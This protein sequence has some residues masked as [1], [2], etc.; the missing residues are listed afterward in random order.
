MRACLFVAVV[1]L[2]AG[3]ASNSEFDA[4][5]ELPVMS[6]VEPSG[7]LRVGDR[8]SI[9]FVV[10]DQ[11]STQ[12]V[13]DPDGVAV[14]PLV[15]P[16]QAAGRSVTDYEAD[17]IEL[18]RPRVRI[19]VLRVAR[20]EAAPRRVYVGGAVVQPGYVDIIGTP[21]DV[22]SAIGTVGGPNLA[23]AD[24]AHVV[25]SRVDEHGARRAW[26]CDL[27][28]AL[29]DGSVPE[30]IE[31]DVVVVPNTAVVRANIAVD[32]YITRMVPGLSSFAFLQANE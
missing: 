28:Q 5:P 29:L 16:I 10:H 11:L 7:E 23:T 13:V 25:V 14:A 3:C 12:V 21:L 22:A 18:L 15:G 27:Q 6:S 9:D 24:L 8:I 20:I 32:Q 31:G 4:L 19:P 2:L 26:R 1:M 30:L 17:L